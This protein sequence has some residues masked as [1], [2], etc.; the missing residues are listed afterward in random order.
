ML[1]SATAFDC[2]TCRNDRSRRV[3]V[4]WLA[5]RMRP[6]IRPW[7]NLPPNRPHSSET[8]RAHG[9]FGRFAT[10]GATPP[11]SQTMGRGPNLFGHHEHAQTSW[12]LAFQLM[13][14]S[15]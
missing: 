15:K 4:C 6:T 11:R 14:D 7:V 9:S 2:S 8:S 5:A 3:V 13:P 12:W 10:P 1:S